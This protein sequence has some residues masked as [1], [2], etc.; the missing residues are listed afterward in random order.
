MIARLTKRTIDAT[1]AGDRN[2]FLWDASL[3]G[4]GVKVTPKNRRVFL[5]QYWAPNLSRV[6]RRVTIGPYGAFT[7]DQAREAALRLQ[8]RVANREDPAAEQA[9]NRI[10]ARDETVE[11]MSAEFLA[12]ARGKIK[13]RTAVEYRR[14]LDKDILPA[15]GRRP[16]AH[17]SLKDVATLHAAHRNSPY[18]A[19]RLLALISALL[20]W[21]E[22]R[23]YRPRASNPCGDIGKYPEPLRE[24]FL[25][26]GELAKLGAALAKAEREGLAPAPG[27]RGR[28]KSE[29]TAKHRPK[30]ADKPNPADPF[31][32]AAIR[33]LLL[34]GWRRSEAL[35]L[36]WSELDLERGAAT[37]PNTKTGR[38]H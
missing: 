12:D 35:G 26:G 29:E 28:P 8:G 6:R 1:I 23:G 2:V 4:F 37:L 3:K 13:P 30:S 36:K 9:T 32:V 19:N 22:T 27:M 17:L 16:I 38:S 31:A 7:V 21:S 33:F 11:A 24:R 15:I 5:F 10:A 18:L 34:T 14:L 20:S 25:T